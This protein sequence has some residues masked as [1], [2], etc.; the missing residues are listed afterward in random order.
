MP[1]AF[2]KIPAVEISC[3]GI[4]CDKV[5]GTFTTEADYSLALVMNKWKIVKTDP[6]EAYCPDCEKVND[7]A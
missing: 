6:L 2:I 7:S 1:I 4:K 5:L 3:D